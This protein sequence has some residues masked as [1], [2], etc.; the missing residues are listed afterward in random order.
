M[1]AKQSLP[2]RGSQTQR[3][4]KMKIFL[5][6]ERATPEGWTRVYW[7][8]EAIELL[9]SGHVHEI[10]LDHDL[11]DDERGTGY[12]VVLWIEEAVALHGFAPPSMRVHSANA[13][14]R[15]RMLAGIAAI[16]AMVA[17][18]PRATDKAKPLYYLPGHGGSLHKGLGDALSQR[19]FHI[20]GRE[21]PGE[22]KT[23]GFQAQIDTIACDL[24]AD[25]WTHDSLV[26]AN[27]YGGYLLLHALASLPPY[28]GKL[29]LLSPIVGD[30]HTEAIGL[31]FYPPRAD[32]LRELAE[33]RSF[34]TPLKAEIHV[35]SED[36]Q[37]HPDA[38]GAFAVATGVRLTVVGGGGHRLG[39]DYVGGVLDRWL[40]SA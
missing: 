13:A 24:H 21:T 10:S 3:N 9:Q 19:G 23:L 36:W 18:S 35:G 7:P 38:V 33:A 22:F 11:G 30:F 6:D 29:L 37:S 32:L 20:Q 28:P 27:S 2:S 40:D 8:R 39:V 31:G 14:G 34:P 25:F 4:Q 5:D 26:V 12:D 17:S 16:K 1:P 15:A